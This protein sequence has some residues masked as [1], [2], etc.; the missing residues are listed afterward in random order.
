MKDTLEFWE[1]LKA[2][3]DVEIIVSDL[4]MLEIGRCSE[5]KLSGL[6]AKMDELTIS[7][8]EESGEH[9]ELSRIYLSNGVLSEK[10]TDDLRHISMAVL[11]GCRYIVSWNFKHFV[12]PKTINAVSATNKMN[13]LPDV[14]IVSPSMMIGGF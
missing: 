6:I 2:R 14:G 8:I 5:P 9:L 7:L 4:T 12:N 10:S 3:N 11:S 13:N 1:I